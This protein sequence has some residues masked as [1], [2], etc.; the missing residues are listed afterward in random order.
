MSRAR[1][2]PKETP[3]VSID[4]LL[5]AEVRLLAARE[6][7]TIASIFTLALQSY[8]RQSAQEKVK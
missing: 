3:G 5:M 2:A 6:E 7:R 1:K 8:I 4:K